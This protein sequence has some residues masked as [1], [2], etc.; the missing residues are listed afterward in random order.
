[1]GALAKRSPNSTPPRTQARALT[2]E[3][4]YGTPSYSGESLTTE[5][6]Y[7]IPTTQTGFLTTKSTYSTSIVTQTGASVTVASYNTPTMPRTET[8]LTSTNRIPQ[9]LRTETLAK[10][11]PYAITTITKGEREIP[12]RFLFAVATPTKKEN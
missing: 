1:M 4:Q 12:H 7:A 11:V 8:L 10:E 5:S 3:S 9:M 6:T 2:M